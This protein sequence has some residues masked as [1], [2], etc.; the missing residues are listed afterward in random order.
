MEYIRQLMLDRGYAYTCEQEDE[1]SDKEEEKEKKEREK[2]E[3]EEERETKKGED[4]YEEN[5]HS[6]PCLSSV[7]TSEP[8]HSDESERKDSTKDSVEY[9]ATILSSF[10][11]KEPDP[12]SAHLPTSASPQSCEES[13][14]ERECVCEE[15]KMSAE[16]SEEDNNES[17]GEPSNQRCEENNNNNEINGNEYEQADDGKINNKNNT[18]DDRIS[19]NTQADDRGTAAVS[20]TEPIDEPS[21]IEDES[22]TQTQISSSEDEVTS[23]LDNTPEAKDVL[24][25]DT[26]GVQEEGASSNAQNVHDDLIASPDITSISNKKETENLSDSAGDG[27]E[28]SQ[29]VVTDTSVQDMSASE[30]NARENSNDDLHII[31]NLANISAQTLSSE[32]AVYVVKD[33]SDM[34]RSQLLSEQTTEITVE[35][36]ENRPQV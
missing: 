29:E 20:V 1:D 2:E 7:S 11:P 22:V 28:V 6:A 25:T 16:I 14:R 9:H 27:P 18:N 5:V 3:E 15:E 31:N 23:S 30:Q 36:N 8:E 24:A 12:D 21:V 32:V 10:Q 34:K 19:E 35:N 17:E 13:D 26:E 33:E 4:E